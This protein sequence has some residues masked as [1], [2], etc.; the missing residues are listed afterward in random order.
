MKTIEAVMVDF[1]SIAMEIEKNEKSNITREKKLI[2]HIRSLLLLVDPSYMSIHMKKH[3]PYNNFIAVTE[4]LGIPIMYSNSEAESVEQIIIGARQMAENNQV[5]LISCCSITLTQAVNEKCFCLQMGDHLET[6]LITSSS[7]KD[8]I[9]ISASQ[10]PDVIAL[11]GD[12]NL[13]IESVLGTKV[14][15]ELIR[16]FGS[17]SSALKN[18]SKIPRATQNLISLNMDRIRSNYKKS[19]FLELTPDSDNFYDFSRKNI[20][21]DRLYEQY[22]S[23]GYYEWLPPELRELHAPNNNFGSEITHTVIIQSEDEANDL[24]KRLL[25][26]KGF[27]LSLNNTHGNGIGISLR[28]GHSYYLP[29]TP[30]SDDLITKI[31]IKILESKEIKKTTH[32]AKDIYTQLMDQNIDLNAVVCDSAILSFT[33]NTH[34]S[35]EKLQNLCQNRINLQPRGFESIS[36]LSNSENEYIA[37]FYGEM[38]DCTMRICRNLYAEAIADGYAKAVFEDIELPF[39]KVIA[40][41]QRHGIK[42]DKDFISSQ[43]T[44]Y[45]EKKN[46]LNERLREI[47]GKSIN[48][49]S[50]QDVALLLKEHLELEKVD[51]SESG[52]ADLAKIHEAPRLILELRSITSTTTNAIDGI[53]NRISPDGRVRTTYMQNV[54]KTTRLSSRDPNLQAMPSK[55]EAAKN[56][57][58]FV[59]EKKK[60]LVSVDISQAELRVLAELSQDEN[61]LRAFNSGVDIHISTASRIFNVAQDK[62]TDEHR[63][64]AKAINFGL[65][66]GMSSFGLANKLGIRKDQ[67][68]GFIDLYFAN[69]PGVKKFLNQTK[70]FARKHGFVLTITGRKIIIEDI[71]SKVFSESSSAERRAVNAPMQAAI[72]DIVKIAMI[73]IDKNLTERKLSS[74]IILQVHDELVAECPENEVEIVT[75]IMKSC[76][77]NAIKLSV[78]LKVEGTIGNNLYKGTAIKLELTEEGSFEPA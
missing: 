13:G 5:V 53:L 77:E 18:I 27:G 43:K 9:G 59:A 57:S 16:E 12:G 23:L 40:K 65:I 28:E 36:M 37:G 4:S 71:N 72:S 55:K 2:N 10:I 11:A 48:T 25:N 22:I 20:D 50:P 32:D 33:I 6:D 73:N 44:L 63:R 7:L 49:N 38:A 70:A 17:V 62:V 75:R 51:T 54:A 14:S 26:S 30:G 74:K 69:F 46:Q 24:Y 21:K 64:T 1:S 66:Y 45:E 15:L 60:K 61:L 78:P 41:I 52:M 29:Y 34:N 39:I 3:S 56:R 8:N 42:I 58:A 67:A 31:A 47:T 68:Q 35:E 76:I 19:N